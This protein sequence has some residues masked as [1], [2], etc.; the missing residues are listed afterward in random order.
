MIEPTQPP[1]PP[2]DDDATRVVRRDPPS[3]PAVDDDLTRAAQADA[4]P[5]SAG[6]L[7]QAH[8]MVGKLINN[9]YRIDAVLKAGGMGEVFRGS[10]LGTG[11]PVAIKAIL[12]QYAEDDDIGLMFRREAKILRQLTDDSIVRYFNFVED[13]SLDRYFLVMEF[14]EGISLW[15]HIRDHGAI[16][17]EAAAAL[18]RRL[19]GGLAK[20]HALEVVHRDLSPDNVML[21]GGRIAEARLIDFGIAR[22]NVIREGTVMGR[23]AGKYRYA[24]P[25]QVAQSPVVGPAADIYSLALVVCAAVLGK[26]LD[27]GVE[28]GNP[29]LA[30]Q[31]IPDLSAVPA[32]LRP[33]LSHMLEPDPAARPASMEQVREL[34]EHPDRIPAQYRAGLPVPPA[35]DPTRG[36]A[37]GTDVP[38]AS[39]VPGLQV[40][41][42]VA[43]ATA[44]PRKVPAAGGDVAQASAGRSVWPLLLGAGLV[45]GL[46][47]AGWTMWRGGGLPGLSAAPE[48]EPTA[49]TAWQPRVPQGMP[50]LRV[51]TRD[52]F[53]AAFD[54]GPCTQASRVAS[55]ANAGM[56]EGYAMAPGLFASL[57]QAYGQ[58][59]G[60][61]PTVV[62]RPV[63]QAQCAAL[64]LA[65]GL[66]GRVDTPVQMLMAA[67]R[68]VSGGALDAMIAVPEGQSVWVVLVSP[69]GGVYNLTGRLSAPEGTQRSL[70]VPL[71]LV[72]ESVAAPHLLLAVATPTPLA[73]AATMRNGALA[74]DVLP[75]VLDAVAAQGGGGSAALGWV[76]LEPARSP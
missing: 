65:R 27:M 36:A 37:P 56:I 38:R 50:P 32:M 35:V 10:E 70:S 51:D 15:D 12:P 11:D 18:L 24:A 23:F 64:D 53:L 49:A 26:P 68:L 19:A 25:E 34:L 9:N 8:G 72:G 59:F 61:T 3:R 14:I 43:P 17:P 66:Q 74:A 57:P 63:T 48:P 30:R 16:P 4:Q 7:G 2:Q 42:G 6:P 55:G 21:P 40:P 69:L 13:P 60:A 67:D 71:T 76:L 44:L 39:S 22:S 52:G 47:V 62:D 31:S 20:A 1:G 28:K 45:A 33:I 29:M 54:A 58:L 46:G 75:A 41:T 73:V 5:A